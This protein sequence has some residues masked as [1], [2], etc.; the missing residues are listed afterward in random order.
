MHSLPPSKL[1]V[2][3]A[4][5]RIPVFRALWTTWLVANVCMYTNDVAA[6]WTMTSLTTSATLI[7]LVQTASSLPVLLLGLPSGA[8]A[9]IINELTIQTT[10]ERL[11]DAIATA[12]GM[13]TVVSTGDTC[14]DRAPAK[15]A[16]KLGKGWNWTLQGGTVKYTG[17]WVSHQFDG[18]YQG[19]WQ[20]I[21]AKRG[22]A[23]GRTASWSARERAAR[24]PW[25]RGS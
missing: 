7:A 10:P 16:I 23:R 22:P 11:F 19:G 14:P 13:K 2:W 21:T 9:D 1:P 8:M 3:L 25:G 5:L 4:P 6:A 15:Y 24:S 17:S 20:V 12:R 18:P